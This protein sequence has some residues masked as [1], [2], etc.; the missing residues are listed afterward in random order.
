MG[1]LKWSGLHYAPDGAII[2]KLTGKFFSG[3]YWTFGERVLPPKKVTWD[4]LHQL[5]CL[6]LQKE[7]R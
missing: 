5:T 2:E 4:E 7:S 6:L 3:K 1:G